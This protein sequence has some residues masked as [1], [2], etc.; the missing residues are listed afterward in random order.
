[1]VVATAEEANGM[2]WL[3]SPGKAVYPGPWESVS[4]L[5]LHLF[6]STL[7]SSNDIQ[8]RAVS[9]TRHELSIFLSCNNPKLMTDN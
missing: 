1:M 9:L 3:R 8:L 4:W 7:V 2:V 6:Q 5:F